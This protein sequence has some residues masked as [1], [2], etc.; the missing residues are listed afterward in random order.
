M[1]MWTKQKLRA[2]GMWTKQK[3]LFRPHF[4]SS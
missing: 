4:Y 1:E 2:I 3:L